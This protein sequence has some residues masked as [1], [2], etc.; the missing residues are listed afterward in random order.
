MQ[1]FHNYT[2]IFVHHKTDIGAGRE[3]DQHL[4]LVHG[5]SARDQ[6]ESSLWEE[7]R[8]HI[9]SSRRTSCLLTASTT[10]TSPGTSAKRSM[11]GTSTVKLSEVAAGPDSIAEHHTFVFTLLL[12][13]RC[14][15]PASVWLPLRGSFEHTHWHHH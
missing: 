6:W 1:S 10:P 4:F 14:R 3:P 9:L 11:L 7:T 5:A 13:R 8:R 12:T 15:G 2:Q